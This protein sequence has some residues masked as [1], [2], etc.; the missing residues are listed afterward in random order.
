MPPVF[1]RVA[2]R[3]F[4]AALPT[5]LLS[6]IKILSLRKAHLTPLKSKFRRCANSFNKIQTLLLQ[7][8][9]DQNSIIADCISKALPL[10]PHHYRRRY[11]AFNCLCRSSKRRK[12]SAS[13]TPP[14]RQAAR[15]AQAVATLLHRGDRSSI[16]FPPPTA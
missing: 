10:A 7:V 3:R 1:I 8:V 12:A 14:S 2:T 15:K 11:Y 9:C 16:K 4:I 13:L 6:L 5:P